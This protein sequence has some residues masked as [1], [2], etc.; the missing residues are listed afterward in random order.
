MA[1]KRYSV[2]TTG[3]DLAGQNHVCAFLNNM[4]EEHRV[5]RSF[6]K[7]AT[8]IVDSE[9]REAYLNRLAETEIR[10]RRPSRTTPG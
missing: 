4:D 1:T 5:L 10:Q 8:H 7:K 2:E 3:M 6:Y 9:N